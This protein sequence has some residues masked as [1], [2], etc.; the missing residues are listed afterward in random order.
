[1]VREGEDSR[2][3]ESCC[4][5]VGERLT[6]AGRTG[7][8]LCQGDLTGPA[9]PNQPTNQPTNQPN[10]QKK[11]INRKGFHYKFV[12]FDFVY[13]ISSILAVTDLSGSIATV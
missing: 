12:I 4:L 9:L 13:S 11:I 3:N 5:L 10:K 8:S 2:V 1:M 6:E 7:R